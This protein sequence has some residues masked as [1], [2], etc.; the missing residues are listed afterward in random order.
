MKILGR[1]GQG[2]MEYLM[3]YGWAI[4]VVMIV[5]V[6]LW[7]LGV[8]Q[9]GQ[10]ATVTTGW[11]KL[12]PLGQTVVYS[13]GATAA[14][15]TFSVTFNNVIGTAIRVNELNITEKISSTT[16]N[17]AVTVNG[18]SFPVLVATGL[19]N[20]SA[21]VTAGNTMLLSVTCPSAAKSKGDTYDMEVT[22][23]FTAVTGGLSTNHVETGRIRGPVEA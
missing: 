20:G 15:N 12:Q 17:P 19:A 22:I 3:T 13:A 6:V 9:I 16:C 5:G 7:Q 10:T 8:F 21:T 2:A 4:L 14:S 1:K 23:Y 18:Q 11:N